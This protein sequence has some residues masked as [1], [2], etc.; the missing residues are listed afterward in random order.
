VSH[1][2]ESTRDR[3]AKGAAGV[4]DAGVGGAILS[5]SMAPSCVVVAAA[6]A[7][8]DEDDAEHSHSPQGPRVVVNPTN[9]IPHCDDEWW[10]DLWWSVHRRQNL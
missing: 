7:A 2:C 4:G 6:A 1:R 10:N 3:A 9:C 5:P 8:G